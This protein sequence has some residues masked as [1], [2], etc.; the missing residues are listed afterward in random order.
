MRITEP[1]TIKDLSAAT[2]VKGAD[3]VKKLFMQ[4]VMANINSGI[5]AEKAQEIMLDWDIELEVV[6]AR[7][8]EEVVSEQF[9]QRESVDERSRGPVV[10]IMGHVDHGKT[11]LLDR[12]RKT[13]VAAGEAGGI[14]QAT[15]ALNEN[16]SQLSSPTRGRSQQRQRGHRGRTL[17][18][19]STTRCAA[20]SP[21][22]PRWAPTW[23]PTRWPTWPPAA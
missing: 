10:T 19:R 13:N 12:I 7:S 20:P 23:P 16:A 22:R 9:A 21:S 8:A 11:S 18:A 6:Q 1:F 17:A 15:S 3:I 4:G 2:G 14:T 5:D